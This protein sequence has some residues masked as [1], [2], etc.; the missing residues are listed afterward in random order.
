[1]DKGNQPIN[2]PSSESSESSSIQS[3]QPSTQA[4]SN[5]RKNTFNDMHLEIE[6]VEENKFV[7]KYLLKHRAAL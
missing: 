5:E 7:D 4:E 6:K 1:M 3:K 2:S